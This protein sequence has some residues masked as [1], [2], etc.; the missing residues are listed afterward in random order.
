MAT[1]FTL[2]TRQAEALLGDE[3]DIVA[4]AANFSSL[5]FHN[6]P[7][8]NWAGFYFR[9]RD[10]LIVGPFQGRPACVRIPMGQG[11]CGVA[12]ERGQTVYVPNVHEFEGHI[13]CDAA[14]Q[15]EVVIPL[16]VG[17]EVIGVFD[18]DSP[19]VGRFATGDV[20]G[21][22]ALVDVYT[23]VTYR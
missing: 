20:D 15:S 21:L 9:H 1:D 5:V 3:T 7:D 23:R 12:A 18:V 16:N 14:S 6:V 22:E 10:E 13:A 8:I 11:V 4:N 2:L 19:S 17:D